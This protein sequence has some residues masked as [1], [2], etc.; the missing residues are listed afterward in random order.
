LPAEERVSRPARRPRAPPA[1]LPR[2]ALG[3]AAVPAGA[4]GF[5]A[6]VQEAAGGGAE[7]LSVA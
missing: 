1:P 3:L 6:G 4:S 7:V 5:E 2:S